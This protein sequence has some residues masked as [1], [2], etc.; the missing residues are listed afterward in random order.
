MIVLKFLADV[1]NRINRVGARRCET[2]RDLAA[3]TTGGAYDPGNQC[4][5][6][7][8]VGGGN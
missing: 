3:G 7:E 1:A 6:E 5:G 2:V 4:G 8:Q